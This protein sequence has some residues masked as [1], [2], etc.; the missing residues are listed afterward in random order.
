VQVKGIEI[1]LFAIDGVPYAWR[2]MCPH[3]GAPVC[4]GKRTGTMLPSEVF[5]YVYGME[6]KILRCPWH[7]W[8]FDLATGRHL[9]VD[10]GAKLRGYR[11]TVENGQIF[12]LLD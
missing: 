8:E 6:E 7:G 5:H 11:L 12:V 2:N 1:G 4:I 10:S 3:A 9:V